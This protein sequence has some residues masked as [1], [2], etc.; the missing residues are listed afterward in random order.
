MK[1]NSDANQ[2]GGAGSFKTVVTYCSAWAVQGQRKAE[3]ISSSLNL[4]FTPHV[5]TTLIALVKCVEGSS[6]PVWS[7]HLPM[8]SCSVDDP[9]LVFFLRATCQASS[10]GDH[11]CILPD[12]FL[13]RLHP[14]QTLTVPFLTG[15]N[16]FPWSTPE[17]P[18]Q[19]KRNS[20]TFVA[21]LIR[22][23]ESRVINLLQNS[24]W[25]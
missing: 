19:D 7:H 22:E 8:Q 20:R 12:C 16:S 23:H 24:V 1:W 21:G 15:P 2:S 3:N 9:D 14:G 18:W 6:V 11:N 25:V 17:S 5:L 10:W 4:L 13:T